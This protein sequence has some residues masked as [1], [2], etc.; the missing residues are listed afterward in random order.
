MREAESGAATPQLWG[1][2]GRHSGGLGAWA[3]VWS[4][5]G[6]LRHAVWA[7]SPSLLPCSPKAPGVT[8]RETPKLER[9]WDSQVKKE[10]H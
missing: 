1:Q 2:P 7:P 5:P 6:F 3:A 9:L 10:I 4:P 8:H